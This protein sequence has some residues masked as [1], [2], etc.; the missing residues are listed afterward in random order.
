M[1]ELF[2]IAVVRALFFSERQYAQCVFRFTSRHN[3]YS[4]HDICERVYDGGNV[5]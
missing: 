3:V 2:P 4:T 5:C 1:G